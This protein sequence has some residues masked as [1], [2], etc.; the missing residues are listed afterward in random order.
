MIEKKIAFR[1]KQFED[2][3]RDAFDLHLMFHEGA[4]KYGEVIKKRN[5]LLEV[6]ASHYFT[7]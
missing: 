5:N 3:I 1:R 6:K 2:K 7:L 4:G